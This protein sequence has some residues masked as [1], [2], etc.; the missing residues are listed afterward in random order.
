MQQV[1]LS[2]G[3]DSLV[4]AIIIWP[5][6]LACGF[7]PYLAYM[8]YLHG[9]KA[10]FS[11]YSKPLLSRNYSLIVA[12]SVLWFCGLVFYSKASLLIGDLG[13][14]L[15]WPLSMAL[16]ILT[17]N[18][19]SWRHREWVGC[20]LAIRRTALLSIGVLI[21]AVAILAYSTSLSN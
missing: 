2:A 9:K 21:I 13:P 7:I 3:A 17:S 14:I 15:T 10:S 19:W 11:V 1:A 8:L 6:F 12:T 16:I 5:P 4:S 18:F 20:R